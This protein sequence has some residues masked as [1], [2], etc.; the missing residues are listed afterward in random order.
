[1]EIVS[2]NRIE[3]LV[4]GVEYFPSVLAAIEGAHETVYLETYIFEHDNTGRL[5]A[6]ALCRA[7][8]RQVQV[9]VLVDGFG[10]RDMA[11]PLRSGLRA[12]GVQ[13][14]FYR[15][16]ISPLTLRKQR[17]RRL[18]RKMVSVDGRVAF[19]GGI[20]II[21][22]DNTPGQHPPR[23]D[24]AVRIEGT[25]AAEVLYQMEKLWGLVS[26]AN[27]HRRWR[28]PKRPPRVATP[29]GSQQAALVIRDNLRHR[30]D[31]EDAYLDAIESAREEIIIANAYFLPGL[32]FRRALRSAAERGVRVHLVLQGHVEYLLL[33]YASRALYGS[34][35][36]AGVRIH[37]YNRG[38]LHAKVAV[39]DGHWSTVGS[40]NIDPFSLLLSREANVVIEDRAFAAA[41]A[42][43]LRKSME[44]DAVPVARS[45][46]ESRSLLQ[47]L[48]AWAAYALVRLLMGLFRFG[49]LH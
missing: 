49:D 17:L 30:A 10:A 22:D 27:L 46:W 34:L 21:D 35:L 13:L 25:L 44:Q 28:A 8:L 29:A 12:A 24:Y 47:K 19:V 11:K 45:H 41:L 3:L 9:R 32:R 23:H 37:E 33:H 16:K 2:G 39:C 43:S 5:I 40:S 15:P 14:L 20:N 26:W 1:M 6:S 31:I 36:A 42:D 38:F 7:A 48:P 4:R 18:H